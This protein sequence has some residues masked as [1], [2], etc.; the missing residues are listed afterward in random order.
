MTLLVLAIILSVWSTYRCSIIHTLVLAEDLRHTHH[1]RVFLDD[2]VFDLWSKHRKEH[3]VPFHVT[4]IVISC[5]KDGM[6]TRT[7]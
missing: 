6:A 4:I 5:P 3:V 7:H 2:D 1:H